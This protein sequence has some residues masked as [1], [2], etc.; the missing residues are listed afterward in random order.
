MRK[1][2]KLLGLLVAFFTISCASFSQAIRTKSLNSISYS[3]VPFSDKKGVIFP[4]FWGVNNPTNIAD[5]LYDDLQCTKYFNVGNTEDLKPAIYLKIKI[6]NSDYLIAAITYG[7]AT[8]YRTDV[9]FVTD[10]IGNIKSTL[11][12]TV[13]NSGISIKQYKVTK[14]YKVIISQ[15]ILTSQEPVLYSDFIGSGQSIEAHRLDTTY[16]INSLGEFVK[17]GE[18][19]F[20]TKNYTEKQLIENEIWDL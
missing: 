19:A 18:K 12:G 3:E 17:E 13:Q 8:D 20:P 15:M 5:R 9:L 10:T 1:S 4:N 6:P 16:G 7:G 14:D 2:I 11:E